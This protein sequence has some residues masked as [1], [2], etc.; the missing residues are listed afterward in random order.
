MTDSRITDTMLSKD[1]VAIALYK[2]WAVLT[3]Y[4]SELIKLWAG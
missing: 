2:L 4:D 3:V 1:S